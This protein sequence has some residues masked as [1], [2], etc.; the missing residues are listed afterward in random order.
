M[1]LILK[2]VQLTVGGQTI[3][4]GELE[5]TAETAR[6]SAEF[7]ESDHS[8]PLDQPR[9]ISVEINASRVNVYDQTPDNAGA[10]VSLGMRGTLSE[11]DAPGLRAEI[12][13]RDWQGDAEDDTGNTQVG[14]MF[15]AAVSSTSA[16]DD[17]QSVDV[18]AHL[19]RLHTDEQANLY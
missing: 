5:L 8:T 17:R 13:A 2:N 18:L 1:N 11:D 15:F 4:L 10:G 9:Q 6:V 19:G 3:T 12:Y 7:T 16:A 14:E